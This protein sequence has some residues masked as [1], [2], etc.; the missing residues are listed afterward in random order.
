MGETLEIMSPLI[1]Y[2]MGGVVAI[3]FVLLAWVLKGQKA[4]RAG[5]IDVM[6]ADVEAKTEMRGYL[7]QLTGTLKDV[8]E[9]QLKGGGP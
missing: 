8:R 3:L 7:E 5:L 1:Q 4:E 6:K 2:G 9:T